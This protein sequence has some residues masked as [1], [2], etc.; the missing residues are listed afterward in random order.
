MHVF[1]SFVCW[2]VLDELNHRCLG[3]IWISTLG[4]PSLASSSFD[5]SLY[6]FGG[7]WICSLFLKKPSLNVRDLLGFA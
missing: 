2:L 4:F 1:Y 5:L 7:D 3:A 6:S